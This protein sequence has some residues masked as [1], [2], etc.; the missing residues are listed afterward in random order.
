MPHEE[1]NT[2]AERDRKVDAP[3]HAETAEINP[4]SVRRDVNFLSIAST[5]N[6]GHLEYPTIQADP[7]LHADALKITNSTNGDVA[8]GEIY[9][10]Y[11][12]CLDVNNRSRNVMV[13]ADWYPAGKY[14]GTIKGGSENVKIFGTLHGHGSEV[15]FDFGNI[16]DQ[17]SDVTRACVLSVETKDGSA[18]KVRVWNAEMPLLLN[19]RDQAYDFV[20]PSKLPLWARRALYFGYRLL[21]KVKVVE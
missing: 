19:A 15:D 12:D 8:A 9:G 6:F 10:G 3:A 16:S 2:F 1:T 7:R 11:E 5:E 17:S 14:V 20:F 4:R 13:S 18:V 21:E